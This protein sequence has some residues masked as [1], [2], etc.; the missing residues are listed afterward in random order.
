MSTEFVKQTMRENLTRVLVPH[1][2]D[3]L[4]S[5]YDNA[6]TACERNQQPEKTI[7]TFQNLLTR[8]PQWTEDV[9]KKEV[10][11]ISIASK[12]DYMEDLLLGVFVSYIR[13]FASLQ[14]TEAQRVNIE[15]DRP[16]IEKFIHTFYILAA[17]KSW[18]T[19][20]LFKTIGVSSEQQARNRR[21]IETM[22]ESVMNEVIDSFIPWKKISQAYFHA[23]EEEACAPAPAPAPA[24]VTFGEP[25]VREFEKEEEEESEDEEEERPKL[26]LGEEITLDTDDIEG[27]AASVDTDTE[28]EQKM[29]TETVSLNL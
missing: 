25:E 23:R 18:S 28:L 15:F 6:K 20:Y 29:A 24:P 11:R 16:S 7:Q 22:L 12:C 21:D 14:Q 1:I 2:A 27:D 9:L 10:E 8:I 3:G 4:W 19:A 17:R 5:I 13:A 26:E